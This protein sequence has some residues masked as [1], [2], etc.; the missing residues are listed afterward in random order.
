MKIAESK[1]T[2]GLMFIMCPGCNDIHQIHTDQSSSVKWSFNDS[3]DNPTFSPSVKVIMPT[4]NKPTKVCHFFVNNGVIDFCSDST[5][6]LAGKS[7]EIEEIEN[8]EW[9][10]KHYQNSGW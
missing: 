3:F 2:K 8:T 4:H 1:N 6:H 5:H 7:V 10:Q 9:Y